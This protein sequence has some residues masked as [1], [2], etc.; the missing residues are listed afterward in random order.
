MWEGRER[1]ARDASGQGLEEASGAE[2]VVK[3]GGR[4]EGTKQGTRA[5]AASE[6]LTLPETSTAL[7]M[8][9]TGSNALSS[10]VIAG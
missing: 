4:G 10:L 2:W 8:T 9:A 6:S 7:E 3:G 5:S 1:D